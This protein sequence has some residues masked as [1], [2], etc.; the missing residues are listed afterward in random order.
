M[1]RW[2][3]SLTFLSLLY[4]GS[5][6]SATDV[7]YSVIADACLQEKNIDFCQQLGMVKNNGEKIINRQLTAL[8]ILNATMF[9]GSVLK[10]VTDRKFEIK[11]RTDIPWIPG[12][13]RRLIITEGQTLIMFVWPLD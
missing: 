5:A 1:D 4:C 10:V 8:G 3:K 7:P 11:D 13:E 9:V 12:N 6:K 2:V